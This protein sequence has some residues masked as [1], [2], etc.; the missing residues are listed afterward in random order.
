[1][2]SPTCTLLA[3]TRMTTAQRFFED[4][5]D[6]IL[7]PYKSIHHVTSDVWITPLFS[8]LSGSQFVGQPRYFI[9]SSPSLYV[10]MSEVRFISPDNESEST[11][12]VV[13][14]LARFSAMLLR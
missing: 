10:H 7:D 6:V 4:S 9:I 14:C 11:D 8:V 2:E 1:M 3:S 13:F 12:P 5:E